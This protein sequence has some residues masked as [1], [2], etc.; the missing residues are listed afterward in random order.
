MAN[1]NEEPR[2][3]LSGVPVIHTHAHTYT[4]ILLYVGVGGRTMYT[5]RDILNR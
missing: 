4:H 1:I 3:L 2:C 5:V